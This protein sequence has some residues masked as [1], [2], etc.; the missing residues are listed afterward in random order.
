MSAGQIPGR[1]ASLCLVKCLRWFLIK[2]IILF[3]CS[4]Q[5]FVQHHQTLINKRKMGCKELWDPRGHAVIVIAMA[6]FTARLIITK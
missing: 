6:P 3:D 5:A 2:L 4:L 1:I